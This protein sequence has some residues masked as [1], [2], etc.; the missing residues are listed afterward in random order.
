MSRQFVREQDCAE[1]GAHAS[2]SGYVERGLFVGTC[3]ECDAQ[4]EEDVT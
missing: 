3:C 2:V 1:C 4:L